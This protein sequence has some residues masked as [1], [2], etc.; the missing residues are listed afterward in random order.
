MEPNFYQLIKNSTAHTQSR[1][2]NGFYI[3][4]NP[5]FLEPLLQLSFDIKDKTHIKACNILEKAVD[6]KID[7]LQPQLDFFCNN[8]K[9][10]QNDSAI[11][12]I[13]RIVQNIVFDNAKNK[14]YITEKQLEKIIEVCFDWLIADIRMA[15]KV[16]AMYSLQQ[17]G[18][19]KTWI[20][21][22]LKSIIEQDAATQSIGYKAAAKKV[23]ATI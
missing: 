1:T 3:I 15:A 11:R 22:D 5:H 21:P 17:I 4:D 6:L 19:T 12:P 8:L 18:K 13:A 2:D 7:I 10:L 23:L 14:N 16:Y 20:Y 9:L